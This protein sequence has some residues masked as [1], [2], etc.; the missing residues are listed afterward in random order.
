MSQFPRLERPKLT[1]A[2]IFAIGLVLSVGVS[3]YA[4][5]KEIKT[6]EATFSLR[7]GQYLK[8]VGGAMG[9][10]L[11]ASELLNKAC[12]AFCDVS[13]EKFT[14][15]ASQLKRR[16]PYIAAL[17][18]HRIVSDADRAAYE[19][20]RGGALTGAGITEFREGKRVRSPSKPFYE[21]IDYA[22]PSQLAGLDAAASPARDDAGERALRSRTTVASN[23]YP[24]FPADDTSVGFRLVKAQ[25]GH[26]RNALAATGFTSVVIQ[27]RMLFQSTYA[28]L[29]GTAEVA[30]DFIVYADTSARVPA[31]LSSAREAPPMASRTAR[32]CL[33]RC[34]PPSLSQTYDWGGKP[35]HVVVWSRPQPLVEVVKG[36]L[37]LLLAGLLASL[38]AAL[39]FRSQQSQTD[40]VVSLV[41]Q[42]TVEL[43]SL[44]AILHN[45]IAAR[46]SLADELGRSQRELRELAEHNARVKEDERK[47][48]AREIHDDL[49]QNMLALRID[50]SLMA[51]GDPNQ[52]TRERINHALLQIDNTMG[53]MRMIINELRP[54]VLDLGLD[55]AV[56]WEVA[57]FHRRTGIECRLNIK[58]QQLV[59]SDDVSTALYRIV[60]ESMTNI[61][62]HAKASRVDV[63]LW[64]DNGWV[65]LT[66]ADNGVGIS[67]RCRRK[68]K[69]FGLIGIAERVYALGGAFDTESTPGKGTTLTIAVP[70]AP[71]CDLGAA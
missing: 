6:R 66:L 2:L 29:G 25:L 5:L 58:D 46:K 15:Y 13:R 62:R 19:Q 24:L 70:Y 32:F 42:R 31:L 68:A 48:I 1:P 8:D 9:D 20:S 30:L 35:W 36:P 34:V 41:A 45:D 65:F 50:L 22:V 27:P 61:M 64:S 28:G 33:F 3:G 52:L 26:A 54:A 12:H 40:R 51:S 14:A 18:Y 23:L 47:R 21:V 49:G 4:Y 71:L 10:A 57:K 69:S 55:A 38:G 44:N 60:Q 59:L 11:D 63:A 16:F 56:E 67:E 17:A 37:S 39:L 43:R 7:A 53:A